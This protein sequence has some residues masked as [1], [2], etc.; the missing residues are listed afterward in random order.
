MAVAAW[1]VL[2]LLAMIYGLYFALMSRHEYNAVQRDIDR[3]RA[4]L[5]MGRR[6]PWVMITVV[7]KEGNRYARTL[8]QVLTDPTPEGRDML[9]DAPEYA[10]LYFLDP[11]WKYEEADRA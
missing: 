8:G 4:A 10:V 3:E 1:T 2:A 9:W 5:A 6:A 11:G 7:D